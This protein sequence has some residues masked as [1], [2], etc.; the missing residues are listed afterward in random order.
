M[1]QPRCLAWFIAFV[2]SVAIW[3]IWLTPGALKL[4]P[5]YRRTTIDGITTLDDAV[6]ACRRTGLQGWDLIAYAQQLVAR[7]FAVYSTRNLWDPPARAFEYGMG[8]CMQYNLALRRILGCLGFETEAIF[9]R[10]V[11]VLTDPDWTMGH[12]WLRVTVQGEVREVCAGHPTNEPGHNHFEPLTPV[13]RGN[14]TLLG[15]MHLGMW[16]FCG[17][18]EWRALLG[19]RGDPGWT[20][21][22]KNEH[23]IATTPGK[24]DD[25]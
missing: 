14:L 10:K 9:A 12:T 3:F 18:A 24:V 19:G 5:H 2:S 4:R 16:P 23:S 7:K 25:H 8:Y 15:L 21:R 17:F 13:H 6:Q 1:K 11:R 20:F 22:R